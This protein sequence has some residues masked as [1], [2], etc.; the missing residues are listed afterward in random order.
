MVYRSVSQTS[1]RGIKPPSPSFLGSTAGKVTLA[2]VIV[3]TI[4][5]AVLAFVMLRGKDDKKSTSTSVSR[6]A[7]LTMES[8]TTNTSDATR[9]FDA[10]DP[11]AVS[12]PEPE[13]ED[14]S[15][16]YSDELLARWP[17]LAENFMDQYFG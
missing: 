5:L 4:V 3:A 15:Q 2:I 11:V 1:Q 10:P 17:H 9:S 6:S 8:T 12:E 16:Q 7:P 13:S 14:T